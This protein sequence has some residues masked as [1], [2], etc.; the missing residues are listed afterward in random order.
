[1]FGCFEDFGENDMSKVSKKDVVKFISEQ[2][3]QF[4]GYEKKSVKGWVKNVMSFKQ[5]EFGDRTATNF[6]ESFGW[7]EVMAFYKRL[8]AAFHEKY[9]QP[10]PEPLIEDTIDAENENYPD[11][12][13]IGQLKALNLPDNYVIRFD[14]FCGISWKDH[15]RVNHELKQVSING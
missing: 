15:L 10:A 9:R 6:G 12:L 4:H 11:E 13:T 7:D 3:A 8:Y 5:L 14:G 1:M 2:L